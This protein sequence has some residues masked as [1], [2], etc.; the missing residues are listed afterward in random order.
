MRAQLAQFAEMND[1]CPQIT[2]Q[3]LPFACG[4]HPAGGG[5]LSILRFAGAPSLGV[6]HLPGSCGGIFLDSPPDVA[7]PCQG[8]HPAEGLRAHP[9]RDR[10]AAPG[11][12]RTLTGARLRKPLLVQ[13][14]NTRTITNIPPRTPL[15]RSPS[16]A[17]LYRSITNWR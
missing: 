1:T 14:A 11:Y 9:G 16:S 7:R 5:P 12:G 3:V 15:D 4:A 8:L 13:T 2:I 10:A 6:V 17:H